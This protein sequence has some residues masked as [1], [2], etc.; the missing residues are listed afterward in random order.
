MVAI[1]KNEGFFQSRVVS[2]CLIMAI[3][4][5]LDA[6]IYKYLH[7]LWHLKTY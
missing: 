2:K 1:F 5:Y 4:K 6:D 7:L 3:N